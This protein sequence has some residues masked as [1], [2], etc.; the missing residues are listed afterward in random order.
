[1]TPRRL[2][3]L[4]GLAVFVVGGLAA[5]GTVGPTDIV[6]VDDY[7]GAPR[8][9][10]GRTAPEVERALGPPLDAQPGAVASYLDPADLR[11]TR[12]LTYS[13]LVIDVLSTGKVRRVRIATPGWGL[14]F[15]LDIGSSREE[16]ERM[17]GEP[18]EATD[19]YLMYLYSDGF[20]ETVHFHL[21]DGG[22]RGIEWNFG[23]AE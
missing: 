12:R 20:P 3:A 22:V 19:R 13:G 10:F 2:P 16:V 9:L 5:A 4:A 1:M 14:P 18:Q 7:I 6:R 23:S 8:V 15:G 21:R 17:L 11:P